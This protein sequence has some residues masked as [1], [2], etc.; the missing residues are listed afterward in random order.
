MS[1]AEIRYKKKEIAKLIKDGN[2]R[3]LCFLMLYEVWENDGFSN[4]VIKK[5]DSIASELGRSLKFVRAM[6]YG[7]LS[8][9][10]AIDFL[11]RHITKNDVSE[12]DPVSRIAVRMSVWQQVFSEGGIPD[13]AACSTA[14][15]IVKKYNPKSANF[16]NAVLRKFADAPDAQK[17]LEQYKPSI[18]ISLKPEIYGVLKM[19]YG[20]QRAIDIGKAFLRPANVTVRFNPDKVTAAELSKSL[21]S[22]GVETTASSFMPQALKIV[23]GPRGIE[24]TKAF[25]E[26]KIFVQNEAAMLASVI[27]DPKPG[28]KILDC[29]AAPGGKSTHMAEITRDRCEITSMDINESRLKLIEQNA[30][31][32]GLS[33]IKVV[34]GD[35]TKLSDDKS[36]NGT[37]DIVLCD[38]PCSGMGLLGRKPDIRQRITFDRIQDLLPIQIKILSEAS[39]KVKPGGALIYCTCT[40]NKEENEDIV[41]E[42]LSE[43]PDFSRV[44]IVDYIPDL[45]T[46][47]PDRQEDV[48]QGQITLFPDTDGCDGFY[49]CRMERK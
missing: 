23:G 31:R 5:A 44:S 26:G 36:T 6:F 46:M 2:D 7:T 39:K 38:V 25:S 13:Y 18:R 43:N 17:Y 35:A 3:E 41:E 8:Y 24:T 9:T 42:F 21:A 20:K 37:Y 47:D 30:E 15:D 29:C 16:V 19:Y 1:K 34:E 40:L 4:L 12:M 14:V 32:L 28:D 22:D 48:E 11:V 27:A 49:I 45:L 10:Y 33:S